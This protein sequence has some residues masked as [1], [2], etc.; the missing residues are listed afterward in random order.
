VRFLS[1]PG[2]LSKERLLV[3]Q[4]FFVSSF[5]LSSHGIKCAHECP[6]AKYSST[7]ILKTNCGRW[8]PIL[9]VPVEHPTVP[10]SANNRASSAAKPAVTRPILP[11]LLCY[12]ILPMKY[13]HVVPMTRKIPN[14]SPEGSP[15]TH[16]QRHSQKVDANEAIVT[17]I[18]PTLKR[19][20]AALEDALDLCPRT[21][22]RNG[23]R[24]ER[25]VPH[26]EIDSSL[27]SLLKDALKEIQDREKRRDSRR[28]CP[29]ME[30]LAGV[31][32]FVAAWF[33]TREQSAIVAVPSKGRRFV[34]KSTSK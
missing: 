1:D 20:L 22:K 33:S 29:S 25:N 3:Y 6:H 18:C 34:S 21:R 8:R 15:P 26:F 14:S 27:T 11:C 30:A 31:C 23:F 16:C 4:T 10:T 24:S 7:H 13:H 12:P 32:V 28:G 2:S 9:E 5:E 17:R 19:L